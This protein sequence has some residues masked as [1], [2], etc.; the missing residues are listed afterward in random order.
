MDSGLHIK[1]ISNGQKTNWRTENVIRRNPNSCEERGGWGGGGVN[2]N[3]SVYLVTHDSK[4][5][6]STVVLKLWGATLRERRILQTVILQLL[7]PERQIN[8]KVLTL[9]PI[10]WV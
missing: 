2:G 4:N 7:K 3:A 1:M 5:C 6:P 8:L 10:E 9:F